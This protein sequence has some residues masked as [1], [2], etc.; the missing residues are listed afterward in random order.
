MEPWPAE[1]TKRSLPGHPGFLGL[2]LRKDFHRTWAIGASPMGMPGCPEDAFSTASTAR[3]RMVFMQSSSR[4][5]KEKSF[6]PSLFH[7]SITPLSGFFCNISVFSHGRGRL[8]RA[9]DPGPVGLGNDYA[10]GHYHLEGVLHGHLKWY[11][12]L[13][14]DYGIE[15]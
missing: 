11:D 4:L 7:F 6:S 2:C 8:R 9:P 1:R 15:A 10:P 14:R 5:P 3:K 12:L 13:I